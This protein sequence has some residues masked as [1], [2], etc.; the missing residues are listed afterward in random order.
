MVNAQKFPLFAK[1]RNASGKQKR[2]WNYL[3]EQ[4]SWWRGRSPSLQC[5]LPGGESSWR[6]AQVLH[7]FLVVI[8][9]SFYLRSF[10]SLNKVAQGSNTGLRLMHTSL[11]PNQYVETF[12][13]CLHMSEERSEENIANLY[14]TF[15][16]GSLR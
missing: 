9:R 4:K 8:F 11:S 16:M 5:L 10:L 15:G 2:G 3:P 12:V 6:C 13:S 7:D 14:P 1:N